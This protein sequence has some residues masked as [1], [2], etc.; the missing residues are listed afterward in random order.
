MIVSSFEKSPQGKWYLKVEGKPFLYNSV[1]AYLKNKR[2]LP[3]IFSCCTK[4]GY[5]ILSLWLSWREVEFEEGNYDFASLQKIIDLAKEYDLRVEIVWGGTNFC[6]KLDVR[7]VPD[8]ILLNKTYLLHDKSKN[9]IYV[10][11]NDMGMCNV[12][13]A[14]S[15]KLL[16]IEKKVLLSII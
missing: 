9:P 4:A 5:S 6:D 10:S 8:W 12:A 3:K 11:G 2:M 16:A 14:K 7:L 15:K 13:N 1:E